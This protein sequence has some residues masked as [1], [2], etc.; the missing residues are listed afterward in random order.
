MIILY[1]TFQKT[2]RSFQ[3]GLTFSHSHQQCMRL[4]ISPHPL[5]QSLSVFLITAIRRGV[6][7]HSV[8]RIFICFLKYFTFNSASHSERDKYHSKWLMAEFLPLR[9]Y[10]FCELSRTCWLWLLFL[11]QLTFALL[12]VFRFAPSTE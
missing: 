12:K 2:A 7:W 4:P 5:Q 1:L 6:T 9:G 8:F 10:K 3:S 11:F